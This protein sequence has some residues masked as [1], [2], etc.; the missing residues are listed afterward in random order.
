LSTEYKSFSDILREWIPELSPNSLPLEILT[1]LKA[2]EYKTPQQ[3]QDHM[4]SDPESYF[5]ES[6]KLFNDDNTSSIHNTDNNNNNNRNSDIQF[7]QSEDQKPS[8]TLGK[9]VEMKTQKEEQ[10]HQHSKTEDVNGANIETQNCCLKPEERSTQHHGDVSNKKQKTK[11]RKSSASN[12]EN[13]NLLD[14]HDENE[15]KRKKQ[16]PNNEPTVKTDTL[17][18][19]NIQL[20]C[21]STD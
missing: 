8:V 14:V 7:Q 20:N 11:K 2:T 4:I 12:A 9:N 16:L 19:S 15:M 5:E 21:H 13:T 6:T 3:S 17:S 10:K 1:E 18:L